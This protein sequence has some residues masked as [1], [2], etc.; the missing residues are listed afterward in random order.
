VVS[1]LD[2]VHLPDLVEVDRREVLAPSYGGGQPLEAVAGEI[3]GGPEA[4]VEAGATVDRADD[5]VQRDLAQ[6]ERD[7]AATAERA[8][9]LIEGEQHVQVA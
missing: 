8:H 1:V 9:H 7:L 2:E 5:V 6:P 3:A 4:P